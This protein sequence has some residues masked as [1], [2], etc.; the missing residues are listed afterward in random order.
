MDKYLRIFNFL[1]RLKR[2]EYV[3][4]AIWSQQMGNKKVLESIKG[5]QGDF[6]RANLLR[7]EILLFISNLGNYIMIEVVEANWKIFLDEIKKAKNLD[8]VMQT[9]NK[10][11]NIILEE[12]LL[13]PK[14]ENI[15]KHLFGLFDLIERFKHT[16]D[17]LYTSGI[18][19]YHKRAFSS[20]VI[21]LIRFR[22]RIFKVRLKLH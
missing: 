3:L 20:S 13:T 16:Y 7:H 17:T 15:C 5:L 9:H 22:I 8:E 4:S 2:A 19:E 14:N 11:T 1:W 18:E 12:V 10:M 6:Q 21:Y